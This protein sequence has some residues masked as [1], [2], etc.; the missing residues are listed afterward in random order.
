MLTTRTSG[1]CPPDKAQRLSSDG[2]DMEPLIKNFYER[3]RENG[4][5]KMVALAACLR[6]M[7]MIV[8]GVL[9]HQKPFDPAWN[10]APA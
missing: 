1:S 2:L 8:Y 9:K 10:S 7:L 3:L 4:K 6:K 5:G